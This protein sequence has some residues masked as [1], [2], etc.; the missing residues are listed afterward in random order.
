[1]RRKGKEKKEGQGTSFSSFFLLVGLIYI[2]ERV[3]TREK[4]E[5]KSSLMEGYGRQ[6]AHICVVAQRLISRSPLGATFHKIDSLSFCL[7]LAPAAQRWTKFNPL[8]QGRHQAKRK[9]MCTCPYILC[10]R[11]PAFRCHCVVVY[12]R[13]LDPTKNYKEVIWAVANGWSV[14]TASPPIGRTTAQNWLIPFLF[15]S[16]LLIWPDIT[17]NI[18]EEFKGQVI[19]Q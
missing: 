7:C 13:V 2:F 12:G 15:L 18:R 8:D 10:N 9:E 19:H 16:H 1:M 11:E 17:N 4:R 6:E 5:K 3:P 14:T